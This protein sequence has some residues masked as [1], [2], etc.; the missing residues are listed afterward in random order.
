MDLQGLGAKIYLNG[1][2]SGTATLQPP[3]VAGATEH[4]LPSTTGTLINSAD[5][6]DML[7]NYPLQTEVT[8]EIHD[9]TQALRD[10]AVVG[11]ALADTVNGSTGNDY[12]PGTDYMRSY[13]DTYGGGELT[14]SILRFIVGTTTG[15]PA[16]GDS[17]I[18]HPEFENSHVDLYR[19][20][21]LSYFH[22][23]AVNPIDST[24]RIKDD[25]I[26][27]RPDWVNNE[28][29]EIRVSNAIAWTD[30][31]LE[32]EE[33]DLLTGL[34]AYYKINE[35]SIGAS[36]VDETG[37]R[38]SNAV[39]YDSVK[40]GILGNGRKFNY[41][42]STSITN[43]DS[44]NPH[45]NAF[46]VSCWI[47]LDSLASATGSSRY[48]WAVQNSDPATVHYL[49][50][51]VD[52]D[53][54]EFRSDSDTPT[55]YYLSSTGALSVDTWYHIVAINQGD[56]GNLKLYVN[57]SDV[58]ASVVAVTGDIREGSSYFRIANVSYSSPANL[59]GIIDEL[60]IWSIAL[61]ADQVTAL[62]YGGIGK[63]YPFL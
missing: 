18:V 62:Y 60:G 28:R 54:L 2:T 33:S 38:N 7:T 3:A 11:I 9:T 52:D 26:V 59:P 10:N 29:V 32:G 6:S 4:T 12:V 37:T 40:T 39:Y 25:T 50:I 27:V 48:I 58:S 14:G 15:A 19:N 46:S 42:G 8:A 21:Y 57:G 16:V 5:T 20:G 22:T 45:G 51:D 34:K 41:R 61:T 55:N 43:N 44:I 56:G 53:K 23:G 1:A 13:V 47:K 63:T 36:F 31:P 30:I 49:A 24:F 35:S 17:L